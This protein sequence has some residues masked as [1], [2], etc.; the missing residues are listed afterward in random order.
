MFNKDQSVDLNKKKRKEKSW[1]LSILRIQNTI[2][3]FGQG[4]ISR[5]SG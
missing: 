3:E 2:E 1:N 4:L 5:T